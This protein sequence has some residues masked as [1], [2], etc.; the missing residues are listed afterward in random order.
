MELPLASV[1]SAF[2]SRHNPLGGRKQAEPKEE[3]GIGVWHNVR[4]MNFLSG[5]LLTG[6]MVAIG[7][8]AYRFLVRLPVMP[9]REIVIMNSLNQVTVA[10]LEY[11]ARSSL[12]GNFFSMNLEEVRGA[13]EKLPW[14]RRA[15]VRRLWPGAL[16][17]RLEEHQPVAYWKSGDAGDLRL[18]NRQGEVFSAAANF[19]LPVL[20]GPEGMSGTLLAKFAEFSGRIS[21][22]NQRLVGLSL[23]ARQAWQLKLADGMTIELGRDQQKASVEDRL[24]RFIKN[25][26]EARNRFGSSIAVA[27]LRYPGG[28]ALRSR[29]G[30]IE[31]R[32]KP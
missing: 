19:D 7:F 14:V 13:F 30:G 25:Y 5:M 3:V 8:V 26:D 22:L 27:D 11:A 18:V 1:R 31:S 12:T 10:Q 29:E 16:E 20:S 28:F 21:P 32:G 2:G 23:S 24:S 4:L 6:V 17:V 9:A 15:D